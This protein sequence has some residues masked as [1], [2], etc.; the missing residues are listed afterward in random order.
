MVHPT[1]GEK[2]KQELRV[3]KRSGKSRMRI[4]DTEGVEIGDNKVIDQDVL[5]DPL[6]PSE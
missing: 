1:K 4:S 5:P 6:S 3:P 2:I